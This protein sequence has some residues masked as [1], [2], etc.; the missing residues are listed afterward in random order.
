MPNYPTHSRYGRLGA[1]AMLIIVT[2]GF[3]YQFEAGIPAL[4]AG[5]TASMTTFVGSIYPDIDHHKSI[6]R[7]KAVRAF[8]VLLLVTIAG[9][10]ILLWPDLLV[11]AETALTMI[12]TDLAIPAEGVA[13]LSVGI[14]SL[15]S[16]KTVDP[17]I[18]IVTRKHRG[19][20]HSVRIN[21][22]LIALLLVVAWAATSTTSLPLTHRS[23]PLIGI[24]SFY[25]GTLIHLGLDDEV[26]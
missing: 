2:G 6:P 14:V 10:S 24:G 15:T 18:G 12:G 3:Y 22:V 20:T 17:A 9:S 1:V 23:I 13:A 21:A 5:G 26:W 11:G 25:V 19:W 4:I 7:R 16:T 8:Q